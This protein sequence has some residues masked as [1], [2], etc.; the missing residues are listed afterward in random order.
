M[1]FVGAGALAFVDH[2]F[3]TRL[4]AVA[5]SGDLARFEGTWR[6][7]EA[8]KPSS[9]GLS[10]SFRGGIARVRGIGGVVERTL[11]VQSNGDLVK[12]TDAG[13]TWH[14]RASSLSDDRVRLENERGYVVL[15]RTR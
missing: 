12:L 8:S 10:V 4:P 6:V 14:A 1:L 2:G 5:A 13:A 3:E 7:V 11:V 9:V 15:E